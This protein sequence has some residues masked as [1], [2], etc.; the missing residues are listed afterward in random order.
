M[1][2]FFYLFFSTTTICKGAAYG[3]G[4]GVVPDGIRIGDYLTHISNVSLIGTNMARV[5]ELVLAS[6]RPLTVTMCRSLRSTNRTLEELTKKFKDDVTWRGRERAAAQHEKQELGANIVKLEEMNS[7]LRHKAK[8]WMLAKSQ[9][10]KQV[11]QLNQQLRKENFGVM[12]KLNDD[13]VAAVARPQQNASLKSTLAATEQRLQATEERLE[14]RLALEKER[15]EMLPRRFKKMI[16]K[17]MYAS[18]QVNVAA[19]ATSEKKVIQMIDFLVEGIDMNVLQTL[20]ARRG[21]QQES[22]KSSKIFYTLNIR[23]VEDM[24][25]INTVKQIVVKSDIDLTFHVQVW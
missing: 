17:L 2:S 10:Q 7:T 18:L 14:R 16:G 23:E 5:V 4:K 3:C 24:L 22:S 6:E 1:D 11:K 25:K 9:L 13:A 12:K 8:D 19:I 15:Q 21:K 20:L